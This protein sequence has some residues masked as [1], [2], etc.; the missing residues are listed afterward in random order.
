M[1][2]L[3]ADPLVL[4]DPEPMVAVSELADSSV[5]LVVRPWC[6]KD[7][8]WTLYFRL[9]QKIKEEFDKA[10]IE[11]PFPQTDVHLYKESA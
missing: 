1:G 9:T 3:K 4:K 10:G 6:K 2:I 8:Y 11:I 7:D 5:N